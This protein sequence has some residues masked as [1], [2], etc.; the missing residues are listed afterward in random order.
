MQAVL[1]YFTVSPLLTIWSLQAQRAGHA[2]ISNWEHWYVISAETQGQSFY[3]YNYYLNK[4]WYPSAK[5]EN[6]ISIWNS[7]LEPAAVALVYT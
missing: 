4:G 6:T 7:R 2:T 1:F 5:S 3:H